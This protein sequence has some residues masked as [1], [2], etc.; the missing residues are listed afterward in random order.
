LQ[1]VHDFRVTLYTR[2]EFPHIRDLSISN[3][4]RVGP[5]LVMVGVGTYLMGAV[6]T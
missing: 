6:L 4:S 2:F 3:M 1:T 5:T